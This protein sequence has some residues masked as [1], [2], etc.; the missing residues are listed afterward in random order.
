MF[1]KFPSNRI[2]AALITWLSFGVVSCKETPPIASN[3]EISS[4]LCKA[5]IKR[6]KMENI[7][8]DDEKIKGKWSNQHEGTLIYLGQSLSAEEKVRLKIIINEESERKGC[9]ALIIE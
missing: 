8:F 4:D 5:V 3:A 6:A 2:L 1:K 9:K 7:S